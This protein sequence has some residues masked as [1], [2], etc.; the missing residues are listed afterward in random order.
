MFQWKNEESLIHPSQLYTPSYLEHWITF[1]NLY[2]SRKKTGHKSCSLRKLV[3][4][5]GENTVNQ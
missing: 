4:T 2:I 1:W 3:N 5:L